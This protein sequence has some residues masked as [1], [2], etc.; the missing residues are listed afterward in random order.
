MEWGELYPSLFWIF[1]FFLTLQSPLHSSYLEF[2]FLQYVPDVET[3]ACLFERLLLHK[4]D[5]VVQFMKL[6][7]KLSLRH[8]GVNNMTAGNACIY[9]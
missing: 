3:G 7:Q 8:R 9:I 2:K 1:E 6:F 4:V 5:L